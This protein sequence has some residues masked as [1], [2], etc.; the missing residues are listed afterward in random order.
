MRPEG[1]RS[2]DARAPSRLRRALRS[3]AWLCLVLAAGAA[4][5]APNARAEE[6]EDLYA[7]HCAVCHGADRLGGMGPA[8]LPE[9]LGR[10]SR[11][12]TQEVIANGR[13]ATQM[14]AF[15][16]TLSAAQIEALTAFVHRA[17]E[18][19]PVWSASHIESSRVVAADA[20]DLPA[21][22]VFTA[23]PLNLFVVVETGDHSVTI[24]D[25]DRF[26]PIA[27]F[28]SRFAL[29]GGPKFS[30]DGRFVYFASR[31]GWISKY[32]LWNLRMVAEV[33]AGINTRNAAVSA[34]GRFV[35]VGNYL[36]HTLVI[37][38]A[39]DLS[40]VRVL[41]VRAKD[42]KSSRVSAVY[43]A[44]P[45]R[46][47]IAALKDVPELWEISHDPHA[48][49]VYEGMVHDYQYGEGVA[50]PGQFTPRR[51]RL[52]GVLD[53]FFF[54]PG[55]AY[56]IGAGRDGDAAQVV[57]LDVRR[58]VAELPLPGL[59]HLA[60]GISWEHQGRLIMATP[61]LRQAVVSVIDVRTWTT[62]KQI[63][64][65]GPGFFMRSHENS[66]YA[67]VDAFNSPHKDSLQVID[68][69]TLEVVRTLTPAPGKTAAHVEFTRDGRYALVSMWEMDGALIIYDAN[70]LQEVKRIPMRK[71]VGKYNVYNKITRSSGTSH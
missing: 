39:R 32:D 50:V 67:W 43:D 45:R 16:A 19:T 64:T 21:R 48:E 55:Y 51:T 38:N 71:P 12:A 66:R 11:A 4:D 61:N 28:A 58:R 15:A 68:K 2:D 6:S 52:E 44:G 59:P 56:V 3:V 65:A 53:D 49:P 42:G 27:R 8:L 33:R 41:E 17:L 30:P 63:P 24:L 37:L 26:E 54:A 18:A 1:S 69:Q 22:P 9:N 13:H 70:T 31:D 10:L 46:S 25:G 57:N 20:Q 60:S 62:L 35:A 36:P 5:P 34:D 40:L 47:F 7:Q 14:P 29:H 23:D